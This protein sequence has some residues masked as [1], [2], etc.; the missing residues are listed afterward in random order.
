MSINIVLN[1][2]ACIVIGSDSSVEIHS[3]RPISENVEDGVTVRKLEYDWWQTHTAQ[4]VFVTSNHIGIVVRGWPDPH[5]IEEFIRVGLLGH[6]SVYEVAVKLQQYIIS[7]F[8][9]AFGSFHVAGYEFKD[10]HYHSR[11]FRGPFLGGPEAIEEFK[12]SMSYGGHIEVIDRL[13][14][15][16][17]TG[18]KS[19]YPA[20]DCPYRYFTIQDAV[21]YVDYLISA[22]KAFYRFTYGTHKPGGPTQL[23][24]LTPNESIWVARHEVA[25]GAEFERHSAFNEARARR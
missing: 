17:E 20:P 2:P 22:T 5:H 11:V 10:G 1:V 18:D 23:L 15:D 9:N 19:T 24:V 16:V 21:D 14:Q 4:S 25:R 8:D 12:G 7:L 6:E 13:I 3:P